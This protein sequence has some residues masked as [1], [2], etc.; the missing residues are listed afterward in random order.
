MAALLILLSACS[1]TTEEGSV[2]RLE[3]HQDTVSYSLG[4]D[5]AQR[6][7]GQQVEINPPVF[8]QGMKDIYQEREPL[9][10]AAESR[11][12]LVAY[13]RELQE[14][15]QER[16]RKEAEQNLAASEAFFK[17]NAKRDGVVS[18]PSGLQYKILQASAGPKP[19]PE[20]RVRVHYEGRLLDG[21]IFDSSYERG[22][23]AVFQLNRVIRGWT[24]AVQLMPVGSIWELYI[25]PDLAYGPQGAGQQIAPNSTLIFKVELLGIE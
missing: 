25:P 21:T 18:L 22:E 20:D 1:R 7:Q 8:F 24:E 12:V 23:P 5:L 17:E 14:L 10:T 16:R 19:G 4:L 3:T 11:R 2:T 15:R 13:R 6:Y 9:L